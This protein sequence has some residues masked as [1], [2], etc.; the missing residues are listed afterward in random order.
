MQTRK[1][2]GKVAL[3]TGASLLVAIEEGVGCLSQ[4]FQLPNLGSSFHEIPEIT[5]AN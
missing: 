2:I 5:I 4:I 1:L 3:V